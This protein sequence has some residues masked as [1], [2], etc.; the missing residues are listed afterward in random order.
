MNDVDRQ[1]IR[2]CIGWLREKGKKKDA[3]EL[4]ERLRLKDADIVARLERVLSIEHKQ[5]GK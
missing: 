1:F 5:A 4:E 2:D 3:D